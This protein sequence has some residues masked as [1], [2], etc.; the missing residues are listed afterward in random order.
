VNEVEYRL[1]D[2]ARQLCV[3]ESDPEMRAPLTLEQLHVL[4]Q[5]LRSAQKVCDRLIAIR[6]NNKEAA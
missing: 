4:A 6:A 5:A 3:L 2:I 1:R